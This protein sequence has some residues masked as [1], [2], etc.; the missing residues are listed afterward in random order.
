M[1]EKTTDIE[2][3]QNFPTKRMQALTVPHWLS[4]SRNV[5]HIWM[6]LYCITNSTTKQQVILSIQE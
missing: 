4:E 6:V 5:G 2:K 1:L 3:Q